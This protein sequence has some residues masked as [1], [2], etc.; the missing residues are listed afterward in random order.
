MLSL[1]LASILRVHLH[2]S[3]VSADIRH[4]YCIAFGLIF[5]YFCFGV[6]SIHISILPTVCYIVVRTQHPRNVQ[7]YVLTVA[8][9]YLSCIHFHRLYYD[10]G[11]YSLDITG[12]LMIITQKVTSLAFSLHDGLLMNEKELTSSQKKFAIVKLPSALEF[13]S[14]V[15]NFQGLMA[16]PLVFYKDY[17]NFVEGR[18]S[19]QGYS[20]M[21]NANKNDVKPP[22]EP[23]PIKPVIKKIVASFVCAYIFMTFKMIYPIK[24]LKDEDF[25]NGTSFFYKLWYINLTTTV[26]RFK[27]YF[28]W[29]TADAIC[30]SAGLGFNGY[31]SDGSPKWDLISNIDVIK[32]EL[33]SNFRNCINSW[34]IG[35]N[36]WL[37]MIVYDRL[38]MVNTASESTFRTILT[39]SLSAIWHGFYPGYY[40]T[41]ATGALI[42]VA[43]RVARKL[44][45]DRFQTSK[46]SRN[47][48]DLLTTVTTRL[49]MGYATFPFV[50]LEFY[51]SV[52]LYLKLFMCLHLVALATIVIIPKLIHSGDNSFKSS[53]SNRKE[54][55]QECKVGNG[56]KN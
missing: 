11:S 51:A 22:V 33:G 6:Q 25:L 4:I 5:A 52:R 1:V 55:T 19:V 39:F 23:S 40:V 27:Y 31:D 26:V 36:Y 18:Y 44:F 54:I 15:L 38:P 3:K 49:F 9:L 13:F 50:L 46:Y 42:V 7:K 30:N 20:S 8:L 34:N 29:L 47:T 17:M 43:A 14:Y 21:I 48:Y 32:F 37:R 35:T 45:R 53:R 41:F 56:N 24:R 28:A 10:Y 16:G 2:P 12:P